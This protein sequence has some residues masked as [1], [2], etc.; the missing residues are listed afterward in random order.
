MRTFE[1]E[2]ALHSFTLDIKHF[3]WIFIIFIIVMF[4]VFVRINT[5]KLGYEI[6][7]IEQD[8]ERKEL[9]LQDSYDEQST[10]T[11]TG[12]LYNA[13]IELG[14]VLPDMK[15]VYYVK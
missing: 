6:Y 11:E 9:T 5:I 8:I 4:I 15:K 12:R 14:L 13:G 2:Y 7:K 1:A 10:L 3:I